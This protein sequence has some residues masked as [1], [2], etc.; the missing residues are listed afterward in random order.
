MERQKIRKKVKIPKIGKRIIKSSLGVF[1]CFLVYLIRGRQGIPFY[2]ALAVLWCIRPYVGSSMAMAVQRTTGTMIGALYGL[3]V[4]LMEVY[5]IPVHDEIV[6]YGI[7]SVMI[8]VVIYTTLLL[9]RK[10]TSYFSCVVFLSITVT[11][12][13]D[14]NPFIFVT[15]RV[16]DTMIG[17]IIG[18]MVNCIK[19]PRKKRKDILFVSGLDDTLLTT[20]KGLTDYSKIQLNRMIDDGAKF[21]IATMRT[22]ASLIQPLSDIHLNLPVIV[23]DGAALYDIKEKE[24]IHTYVISKNNAEKIMEFLNHENFN[25]FINAIVD[26]VLMIFYG[27][28]KN[29]VEEELYKKLR[30][31]PYRNYASSKYFAGGEVVYF[32]IIDHKEKILTLYEQLKQN[33]FD[34]R[35][36]IIYYDSVD[37]PG[38]SYIKIYNK[39]ASKKNMINHLKSE[40]QIEKTITF[41]SII[42]EYDIVVNDGDDNKVVKT[43]EKIYEP[44]IC[45]K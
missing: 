18:V 34:K 20:D 40:I 45:K 3:L 41:G 2:S 8:V 25:Y 5:L 30:K 32:M 6:G 31:S 43:L 29:E 9:N 13:T 39:N 10:N 42:G 44:M 22:P 7:V 37:Y 17:I 35:L 4:I 12:I 27:E 24:Y 1:L 21:T 38:Y 28:F 19:I 15:N 14:S 26:E 16:L 33:E 36:K 11:H 23:M